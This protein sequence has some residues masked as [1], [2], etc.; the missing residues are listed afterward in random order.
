MATI[1]VVDDEAAIRQLVELILKM[2]GHIVM[3]AANGLEALMVFSSYHS[4]LDMVLTDVD[5]PQMDGIELVGRIRMLDP[6]ARIL[7]MTGRREDSVERLENCPVLLKPF[8]PEQ[9][10]TAVNAVLSHK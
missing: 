8:K 9:L 5:M 10:K 4:R 2:N 6:R 3:E 1:L 7:V